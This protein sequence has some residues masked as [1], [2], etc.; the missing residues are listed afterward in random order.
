M[1]T[2]LS[3]IVA[4]VDK[5]NKDK[6]RSLYDLNINQVIGSG[7]ETMNSVET[8]GSGNETLDAVETKDRSTAALFKIA[9]ARSQTTSTA[10]ATK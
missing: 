10:P 2:N 7:N 8:N 4:S 5:V 6:V 9:K 1:A 3:S